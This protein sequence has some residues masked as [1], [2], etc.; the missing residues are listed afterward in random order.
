MKHRKAKSIV[1]ALQH[2]SDYGRRGRPGIRGTQ[3]KLDEDVQILLGLRQVDAA[4]RLIEAK[5]RESY[6]VWDAV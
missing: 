2:R 4:V 5:V 6:K 1:T 3:K